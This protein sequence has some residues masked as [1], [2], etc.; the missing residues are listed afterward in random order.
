MATSTVIA[1]LIRFYKGGLTIDNIR[2]MTFEQLDIWSYEI[3]VIVELESG[4]KK[5]SG[6][7]AV[8]MAM[9]DPAIRKK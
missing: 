9:N 4:E 7:E 5:V 2:A 1:L 8:A 6:K 3:G